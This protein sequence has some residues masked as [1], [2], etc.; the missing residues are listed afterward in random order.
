VATTSP[1]NT[2]KPTSLVR[3]IVLGREPLMAVVKQ[4]TTD[5]KLRFWRPRKPWPNEP[6]YR[7]LV[8]DDGRHRCVECGV[9]HG[10]R[11]APGCR[12]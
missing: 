6:V 5:N 8:G 9:A 12:R 2:R 10:E 3:A 7:Y 4:L 11:H 1:C